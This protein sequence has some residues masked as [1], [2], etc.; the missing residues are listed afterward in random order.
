MIHVIER[1]V[2]KREYISKAAE[3][4]QN[5][6]DILGPAAHLNDGWVNHAQFLQDQLHRDQIVIVYQWKSAELL[7]DLLHKEESQL[8]SFYE[9]YCQKPREVSVFHLL[10]VDVD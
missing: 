4:M 6:D 10:P 5:L 3:V 2:L 1:Y 8:F 9:T 7:H